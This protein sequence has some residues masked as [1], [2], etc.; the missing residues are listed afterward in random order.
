MLGSSPHDVEKYLDS[1]LELSQLW[2]AMLFID[3]AVV[4]LGTRTDNYLS[5]NELVLS[6]SLSQPKDPA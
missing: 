3:E 4:F 6:K 1:A 5:R 2:N